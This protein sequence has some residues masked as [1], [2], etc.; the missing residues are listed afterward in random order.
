MRSVISGAV[1]SVI[2]DRLEKPGE[3]ELSVLHASVMQPVALEH[4]MVVGAGRDMGVR[5]T[6]HSGQV[7]NPLEA[8][9]DALRGTG[10]QFVVYARFN[11]GRR[12]DV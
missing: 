6:G 8:V 3:F 9:F 4:L 11:C 2:I 10:D 1:R 12:R 7:A 5:S